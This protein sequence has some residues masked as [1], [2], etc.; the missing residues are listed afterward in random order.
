M[1]DMDRIAGNVLNYVFSK[2]GF[3]KR[4]LGSFR[5]KVQSMWY[6]GEGYGKQALYFKSEEALLQYWGQQ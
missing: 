2:Y 1:R 6:T 5:D 4:Q 3:V